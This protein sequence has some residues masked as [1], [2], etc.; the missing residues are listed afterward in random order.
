MAYELGS[1]CDPNFPDDGDPWEEYVKEVAVTRKDRR[2][3][4]PSQLVSGK[5]DQNVH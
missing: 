1:L 4:V 5:L 2:E 3:Y